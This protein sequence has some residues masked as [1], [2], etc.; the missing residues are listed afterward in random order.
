MILKPFLK[1][2]FLVYMLYAQRGKHWTLK[3]LLRKTVWHASSA[4]DEITF[5]IY[6]L[7]GPS[8]KKFFWHGVFFI[9]KSSNNRE[10]KPGAGKKKVPANIS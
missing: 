7:G 8:R 4:C 2:Y 5:K 9:L 3:T 6:Q 1:E 10:R